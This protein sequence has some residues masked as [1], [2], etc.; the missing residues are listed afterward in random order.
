MTPP[1]EI[2]PP[3]TAPLQRHGRLTLVGMLILSLPSAGAVVH[4]TLATR[5]PEAALRQAIT[6]R[7]SLEVRRRVEELLARLEG[8][9]P[10]AEGV[11]TLRAVEAL[12]HIGT[13]EARQVLE[14]LAKGA[15]ETRLTR[16]V[17]AALE[18]LAGT[19]PPVR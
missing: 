4:Q 16:E 1:Q 18:R 5:P 11:R 9:T 2:L 12:E 13:R 10:S 19:P 3:S 6:S 7:P 15:P 17:K 14:T 8:A